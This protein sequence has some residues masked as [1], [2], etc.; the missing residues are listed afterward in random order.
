M[1]D[2][3]YVRGDIRDIQGYIFASPVLLEMRGG[4]AII[5]FFD[6]GVVP[7]LVE[8]VHGGECLSSGGG[9]FL[10]VFPDRSDAEIGVFLDDVRFAFHDLTGRHGP[11]LVHA[12]APDYETAQ[13]QLDTELR[14]AKREDLPYDDE[15]C[16]RRRLPDVE[17][18]SFQPD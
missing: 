9:N 13:P 16:I 1:T 14:R 18:I 4:S 10:A 5:D 12:R 11:T 8:Q 17:G 15:E 2:L 3:V 6:R 7:D